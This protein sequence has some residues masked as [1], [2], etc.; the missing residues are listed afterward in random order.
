[1]KTNPALLLIVPEANEE[2]EPLLSPSFEVIRRS[3]AALKAGDIRREIRF[4]VVCE[5]L[6]KAPGEMLEALRRQVRECGGVLLLH[7]Q[8][9]AYGRRDG[10]FAFVGAEYSGPALPGPEMVR[11]YPHYL[12]AGLP[13]TASVRCDTAPCRLHRPFARTDNVFLR[14]MRGE[15]L[16]FEKVYGHKG[17][18]IGVMLGGA[19]ERL[20]EVERAIFRNLALLRWTAEA[21]DE[22]FAD[23]LENPFP[24]RENAVTEPSYEVGRWNALALED[25]DAGIYAHSSL[26]LPASP[27]FYRRKTIPWLEAAGNGVTRDTLR[28]SLASVEI[29]NTDFC[30]QSCFY[31]YNRRARDI[32]HSPTSLP[33]AVH[34][35]LEDALLAMRAAGARFAVRYTGTGEPLCH[36]RTLPSLLRFEEAGIPCI[37]VTNGTELC[38][39]QATR[40]GRRGTYVRI[41]IDAA[42]GDSYSRIRRCEETV[43]E[44]VLANIRSLR[45]GGALLGATFLV[46]RKNFEQIFGFCALMKRLGVQ[47]VWI[48]STD[49]LDPFTP[50]EMDHIQRQLE[51]AEA[52]CDDGFHV[53]SAQFQIFRKV[54]ALH[55]RYDSVPCWAARTKVVVK[56][57]GDVIVCLSRPDFV[58]GNLHTQKFSEI[59]GGEKHIRFLQTQDFTRCT[60]C[61]ESRYNH[62][63]EFFAAHHGRPIQKGTRTL[64]LEQA[65]L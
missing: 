19:N 38:E 65:K 52:L 2:I 4:Y 12:T 31:C 18:V 63:L 9:L 64:V 40:L 15:A 30:S 27:E 59:W 61:I 20:S 28:R 46:C 49:S 43:F 47:I 41:S 50:E 57:S 6:E 29:Q 26:F 35:E 23:G 5:S 44:K 53:F 45:K 24:F 56:P 58:L 51:I 21:V 37:L 25:G 62:S 8:A 60:Q 17:R 13:E 11:V 36:L 32:G 33:D 54:T 34:L 16:A 1:M 39:E 3:A 42:H 7:H 10:F 22:Y 14:S 48:R 55:Y